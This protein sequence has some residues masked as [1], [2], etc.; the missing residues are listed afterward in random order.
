MV[1]LGV[2]LEEGEHRYGDYNLQ[3]L[4]LDLAKS[5]FVKCNDM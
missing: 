1:L 5:M 3:V 4:S 2:V